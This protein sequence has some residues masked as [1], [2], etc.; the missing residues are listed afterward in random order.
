MRSY[1]KY[2]A[3]RKAL[4]VLFEHFLSVFQCGKLERS[5]QLSAVLLPKPTEDSHDSTVFLNA[6]ARTMNL[7]LG[8][9]S[10]LSYQSLPYQSLSYQLLLAVGDALPLRS[11]SRQI[12]AALPTY[13]TSCVITIRS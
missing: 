6:L 3:G 13:I 1:L 9:Q 10:V 12:F 4:E 11:A 2:R 7:C 5:R 8:T